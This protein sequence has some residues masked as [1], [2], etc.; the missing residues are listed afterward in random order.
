MRLAATYL[1]RS[2]SVTCHHQMHNRI[3][4]LV[5]L[6][7]LACVVGCEGHIRSQQGASSSS[8]P[9]DTGGKPGGSVTSTSGGQGGGNNTAGGSS[10]GGTSGA[11]PEINTGTYENPIVW[12]DFPD[13]DVIRVGND[14]YLVT[15]S[16]YFMPGAPIL[17]STDLVHWEYYASGVETIDANDACF[18]LQGCNQLAKGQWATAFR[19]H[20]GTFYLMFSVL[21]KGL[22]VASAADVRG[23][24]TLRQVSTYHHDPGLLFDDDGKIYMAHGIG[25]INVT[26][27]DQN[28]AP[29]NGAETPDVFVLEGIE[30]SHFYKIDGYYYILCTRP[31]GEQ[32]ALRAKTPRGPYESKL[33]FKD[34]NGP[35]SIHQA[36]LVNTPR[37]EWWTL[38]MT[39][40]YA[41]HSVGRSLALLPA[42]FV[43]GWPIIGPAT[44]TEVPQGLP[45][46]ANNLV[47][48]DTFDGAR[49]GQQ[50]QWSHNPDNALWSLSARSGY[51]SL[52]GVAANADLLMVRNH[53]TQRLWG[54]ASMATVEVDVSNL[55]EGDVAG[56]SIL[57]KSWGYLGIAVRN[58]QKSL[59]VNING[60][61]K[62]VL[63]VNMTH[64][65]LRA[66]ADVQTDQAQ[67]YYSQDNATFQSVGPMLGMVWDLSIFTGNRFGLFHFNQMGNTESRFDIDAVTIRQMR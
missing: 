31:N 51:L 42:H 36:S 64:F 23:P 9:G 33:I 37:G 25:K 50:W 26:E 34:S 32:Y 35:N 59:V 12:S 48:N 3:F 43:D 49:L 4:V 39:E 53:L 17:H 67:F 28:F 1:V 14:F 47:I 54:P 27:L 16:M 45:R 63:P 22:Y 46:T 62:E 38:L 55:Q 10:T 15:T 61:D 2:G 7:P 24:W 52:K 6:L 56:L 30:G 41:H 13:P 44:A 57:G 66:K 18:N 19:E 20:N 8:G 40:N 60:I 58:G 21:D 5:L 29:I 11:P 65:Y